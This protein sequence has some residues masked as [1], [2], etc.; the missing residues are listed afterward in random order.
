M[1][2]QIEDNVS[3][4]I[5]VSVEETPAVC[6]C[7]LV[8]TYQECLGKLRDRMLKACMKTGHLRYNLYGVTFIFCVEACI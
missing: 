4:F 2:W 6:S 7:H 8:F 1:E 5:F 3:H